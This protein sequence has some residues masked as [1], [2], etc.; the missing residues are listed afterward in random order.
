M[1]SAIFCANKQSHGDIEKMDAC[2]QF[3]LCH[4][5]AQRDRANVIREVLIRAKYMRKQRDRVNAIREVLIRA[6]YMR[7][8]RDRVN[9]IH[10]VLVRECMRKVRKYERRY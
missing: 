7:K 10:E 4:Y 3:S 8:Q 6:K 2:I 9:A 5:D 1:F